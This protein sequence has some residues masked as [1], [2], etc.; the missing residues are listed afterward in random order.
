[1]NTFDTNGRVDSVSSR[2]SGHAP[3]ILANAFHYNDKG[4][5]DRLRL[6]NGLW[7]GSTVNSRYQTTQITLGSSA[8][9]SELLKLDYNYVRPTTTAMS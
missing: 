7:E 8:G 9:G 6:G 5:M 3:H 4:V 1:M 2:G